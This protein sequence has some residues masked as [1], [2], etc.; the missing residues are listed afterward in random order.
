MAVGVRAGRSVERGRGAPRGR[1]RAPRELRGQG[2]VEVTRGAD[3]RGHRVAV[4]ADHVAVRGARGQMAAVRPDAAEGGLGAARGVSRGRGV[5][6]G[7][8]AEVAPGDAQ[9]D[10]A[11][12]VKARV[13]EHEPRA[14]DV[15]VAGLAV[16]VGRV[17]PARGEAV[18]GAAGGLRAP[19]GLGP[20]RAGVRASGEQRRAVAVGVRAAGSVEGGARP[21]RRG[22]GA[23]GQ[24]RRARGIEVSRREN[25]DGHEVTV[26]ALHL[27]VVPAGAQVGAVGADTARGGVE[28][29]RQTPGRRGALVVAVADGA[30]TGRPVDVRR[31]VEAHLGA[32]VGDVQRGHVEVAR[33]AGVHRLRGDVR[34]VRRDVH[35]SVVGWGV[36]RSVDGNRRFVRCGICGPQIDRRPSPR[37]GVGTGH[38]EQHDNH[39]PR[40]ARHG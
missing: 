15:G 29:G 9:V 26:V 22:D 2:R 28:L 37:A 3:A 19:V 25:V 32:G 8:V 4:L 12:D 27:A 11:V 20:R 10:V 5:A 17:S 31:S 14:D 18:T 1:E 7:A 33:V 24:L 13:H 36:E 30:G 23:P 40:N 16:K 21:V 39:P 35:G 6:R 38:Q 34:D